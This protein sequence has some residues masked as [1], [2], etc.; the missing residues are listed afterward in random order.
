MWQYVNALEKPLMEAVV[1]V[2]SPVLTTVFGG[3]T[4]IGTITQAVILFTVIYLMYDEK[5]GLLGWAASITTSLMVGSLKFI[6]QRDL[7]LQ[8]A[9]QHT[10]EYLIPY[11][12]PSGHTAVAFSAATV[13][14]L[15]LDR[16]GK[17]ILPLIATA[18]G[19]SRLYLGV[20]YL[21]DIIAGAVLGILV[22]YIFFK[23]REDFYN[24]F[25]S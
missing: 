1:T 11:G 17:Y 19:A 12:F 21:S 14:Y 24:L 13:L 15:E 8:Y 9:V 5:L 4:D 20:H 25:R 10:P 7:P 16:K 3:L 6:F 23:E 18:V 22:G 2:R